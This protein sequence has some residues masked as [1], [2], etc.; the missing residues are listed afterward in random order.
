MA[1]SW[2]SPLFL[3]HIWKVLCLWSGPR[4]WKNAVWNQRLQYLNKLCYGTSTEAPH[5]SIIFSALHLPSKG[6]SCF[7]LQLHGSI[8][9]I[10]YWST[11]YYV[12][13]WCWLHFRCNSS[14]LSVFLLNILWSLLEGVKWWHGSWR[15]F[16]PTFVETALFKG[17]L[18]QTMLR[19]QC[20]FLFGWYWFY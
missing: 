12:I 11:S 4:G 14:S 19:C 2:T 16:F 17:E 13:W 5:L 9:F 8:F 18:N 15:N 1:I 7:F 20:L 6:H 3:K 10:M